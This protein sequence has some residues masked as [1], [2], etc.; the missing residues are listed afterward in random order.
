MR[1]RTKTDSNRSTDEDADISFVS[2]ADDSLSCS[3]GG[4]NELSGPESEKGQIT[5]QYFTAGEEK[6]GGYTSAASRRTVAFFS[7]NE[8]SNE[9]HSAVSSGDEENSEGANKGWLRMKESCLGYE[10]NSFHLDQL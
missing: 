10:Q 4:T 2:A 7:A 8:S 9:F 3:S 1:I 5:D 6:E